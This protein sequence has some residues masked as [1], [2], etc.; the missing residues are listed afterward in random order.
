MEENQIDGSFLNETAM[1]LWGKSDPYEPLLHHMIDVGA[2]AE[3]YLRKANRPLLK[4][5]SENFHMSEVDTTA[6]IG[7]VTA[8]H[9][10]GKAHPSF[11]LKGDAFASLPE[12]IKSRLKAIGGSFG[13]SANFRHEK[14]SKQILYEYWIRSNLMDAN[15]ALA[16]ASVIGDHHQKSGS[17]LPMTSKV[18]KNYRYM[19]GVLLEE[20]KKAFAPSVFPER[21]DDLSLFGEGLNGILILS[22]WLASNEKFN[23]QVSDDTSEYAKNA[24][25]VAKNT[26]EAVGFVKSRLPDVNGLAELYDWDARYLRPMQKL[27]D[28]EVSKAPKLTI[29]EDSPGAGKTEAAVFLAVKLCK[30]YGKDGF[31]FALPTAAT[32]NQM[33]ERL[34]NIFSKF[35]IPEFRLMHGMAWSVVQDDYKENNQKGS[36]D[37]IGP[38]WLRP[39]RKALLS[40]F[41]VGT[42]DQVMMSVMK[43]RFRPLRMLGLTD[44]VLVID[45]VHAYDAYMSEI[46]ER[47]LVGCRTLHIPVIL[48]SATLPDEKKKEFLKAY[49]GLEIGVPIS[50]G[51]P[52]LTMVDKAGNVIQKTCGPFKKTEYS[53]HIL[54]LLNDLEKTAD[55]ALELTENG[56]NLCLMMN[57]VKDAQGVYRIL[58]RKKQITDGSDLELLLYHARFTAGDRQRIE[59]LCLDRYSGKQRPKRSILVC[60][61][62]VEQSLDVDFDILMTQLCPID[63]LIQRAGREW[64]HDYSVRPESITVPQIYVLTG[65]I[66]KSPVGLIYYPYI[67]HKT[68]KWL[69]A[70]KVLQVPEDVRPAIAY[71]YS[72]TGDDPEYFEKFLSEAQ[73]KTSG[74]GCEIDE[75]MADE[76]YLMENEALLSEDKDEYAGVATRLSRPTTRVVLCTDEMIEEYRNNQC[77]QF[78]INRMLDHSISLDCDVPYDKRE[79]KGVLKG[80]YLAQEGNGIYRIDDVCAVRYDSEYG[81]EK[82]RGN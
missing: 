7:Y 34:N 29:I 53:L 28:Q 49:T 26:V 64:R 24:F 42:V 16:A 75:P 3:A 79:Q 45:E 74:E 73:M 19:Q 38:E 67:L 6:F 25:R 60:T 43:V 80:M 69:E 5:L 35:S 77:L 13:F 10:I 70:N 32:S 62:V 61:Q 22:D 1:L 14:Y 9:D 66:K 44:K 63:L 52:L 31:Y 58:K 4:L 65:D 21:C 15:L 54:P 59:K 2:C 56:G 23:V 41:A 78:I 33:W 20:V 11:Q 36:E 46:I 76:Y 40:Q 51:Y 8:C 82:I 47:L 48:L 39:M 81:A 72:Q 30:S 57:T 17:S 68:E 50:P 55:K 71:V 27:V 37:E 18:E 12:N